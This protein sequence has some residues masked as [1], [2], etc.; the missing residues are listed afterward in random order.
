MKSNAT[1]IIVGVICLPLL[2]TAPIARAGDDLLPAVSKFI[3]DP[4]KE[5]RAVGLEQVRDGLKGSAATR[6]IVALLPRLS[7]DGQAALII[8]LGDRGDAAALPEVRQLTGSEVP[9][10]R[11]AAIRALGALGDKNEVAVLV[12]LLGSPATEQDA[13]AAILCLNGRGVHEAL[14]AEADKTPAVRVKVF[15]LLVTRHA[16]EAVP[17]L[18][19]AAQD[20]DDPTRSAAL[21][22]LGQLGGPGLVADLARLVLRARSEADRKKVER[23]LAVLS[24]RTGKVDTCALPLLA[25]METQGPAEKAQL[26]PALG[27]IGGKAA[28]KVVLA[29]LAGD[30][31][32][33]RAA[34][35]Q[36]LCNWPDGTVS[37]RLVE[38]A[39]QGDDASQRAAALEALIRVAPLPNN[40]ARPESNRSDKERLAMLKKAMELSSTKQQ[41]TAILR[42]AGAIYTVDTL[43]FVLPY[44]DQ[45][46]FDQATAETIVAI[47]HHKEV[48]HPHQA[49]FDAVLDR[50]LQISK[51]PRVIDE[52]KR[53]REDRT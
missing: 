42:R 37:A 28:L 11:A 34:G 46:E 8:A 50:V 52:A 25:F 18:L 26:F 5:V 17:G 35:F 48:R 51:N 27:R 12:P 9:A 24:E 4:D 33:L 41:K 10:I 15:P 53:Y 29:G 14:L 7:A 43:H 6:R 40:K 44:L 39:T 3:L 19:A 30:D 38:I 32:A 1:L 2:A 47:A 45:P 16:L 20:P 22:A 31:P 49:E 13:A 36:A 21:D 23:A